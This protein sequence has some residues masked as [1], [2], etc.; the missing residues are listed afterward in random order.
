MMTQL[1]DILAAVSL[2]ALLAAALLLRALHRCHAAAAV[3]EAEQARQIE[4]LRAARA[5]LERTSYTD[6]LTGVWNYRYLQLSLDREIARCLRAPQSPG[7]GPGGRLSLLLLE[8]EGFEEIRREHGYQRAGVVLRDLAQRLALEFRA[9]D[10]FG[11]YGGEEFLVLLPDTDAAGAEH[12]AARL[13]WTV[14]RH[15]LPLPA[16]PAAQGAAHPGNGLSAAVGVASLPPDGA[17]AALLLRAAERALA[18][19][20][21]QGPSAL[22]PVSNLGTSETPTSHQVHRSLS[23]GCELPGKTKGQV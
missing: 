5:V 19:A 8:V 20:R 15:S 9:A 22:D 4:A 14:R 16:V 23:S 6:P 18:R 12:A 10:V 17:H 2:P 3:R 7:G 21:A 11:R 1:Y 13:R